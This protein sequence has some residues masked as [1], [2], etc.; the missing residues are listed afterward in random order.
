[1]QEFTASHGI[2]DMGAPLRSRPAAA[3]GGG[4]GAALPGILR[5]TLALKGS[6][7]ILGPA[8]LS[9]ATRLPLLRE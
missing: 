3:D 2:F 7:R 9:S 6:Q 1:M 5:S 8:A 4:G